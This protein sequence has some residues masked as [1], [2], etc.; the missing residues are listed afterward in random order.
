[1]RIICALR[2]A[3]NGKPRSGGSTV[4]D[5]MAGT[6]KFGLRSQGQ[7]V[8]DR[9]NSQGA[10]ERHLVPGSGTHRFVELGIAIPA[11]EGTR[12]RLLMTMDRLHE[13]R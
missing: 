3:C 1:M 12:E 8:A 6:R 10:P 4:S 7:L 13:L 9:V 2:R 11:D 5:P